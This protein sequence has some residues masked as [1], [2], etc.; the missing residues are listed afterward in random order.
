MHV[1]ASIMLGLNAPAIKVALE[2]FDPITLAGL[3]Y[4]VAGMAIAIFY[5]K[6]L[7]RP[8]AKAQKK[9]SISVILLVLFALAL[10]NGFQYSTALKAGIF[11]LITP[12][13]TYIFAIVFLKEPLIKRALA[14]SIIGLVGSLFLIGAPL[15]T[16]GELRIGDL[17][18]V[19]SSTLL[20]ASF[21]YA[22]T[23]YRISRVESALSYRNIIGGG[24]LLIISFAMGSTLPA[25]SEIQLSSALGLVYLLIPGSAIAFVMFHES[26]KQMRA[27]ETAPIFYL[28]P[29]ATFVA[30]FLLLG[31]RLTATDIIG[32]IIIITGVA[33]AHPHHH[34]VL[35]KLQRHDPSVLSKIAQ[36]LK[37]TLAQEIHVKLFK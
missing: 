10:F 14:G 22:K 26:L 32:A 11:T 36:F 37:R 24:I 20:G 23:I 19:T 8:T 3:R 12:L 31:D 7:V 35:H 13:A 18:F 9:I 25:L 16:V 4:F 6:R 34:K 15:L 27:E 1:T 2:S 21:V 5:R 30:S 17:L 29:F 33:F 28:D